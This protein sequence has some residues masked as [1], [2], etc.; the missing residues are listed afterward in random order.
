MAFIRDYLACLIG[1]L[2]YSFSNKVFM[3]SEVDHHNL[4]Q[5]LTT[6]SI[7]ENF[8]CHKI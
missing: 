5:Q 7:Q 8:Y 2:L 6:E 4:F 1:G 3:L